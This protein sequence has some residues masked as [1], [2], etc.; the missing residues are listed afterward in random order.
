MISLKLQQPLVFR[1]IFLER[2]WGGRNLKKI[3][4]KPVPPGV[5]IGEAWEIV[6]RPEAQSVI[7][8]GPAKGRSLHELW[9]QHRTE[10]FGAIADA[11]RFPL[12]CKI[13]DAEE[14]LSLQVHPPAEVA[15]E[16]GGEAKTEFW[17]IAHAQP[18]AE[19]FVGLKKNSSRRSIEG[20]LPN[21][22]VEDHLHRIRVRDGD[23][24]FLPSGRMHAIGGGNVL[25]EVQQNS[26]TTYRVFDWNREDTKGASRKLHLAESMRSIDFED[27]EPEL[28]KPAGESLVR[29]AFFEIE[30]WT[31]SG[32]RTSVPMGKFAIFVCLSGKVACA[33]MSFA[34]GEFFLVPASMEN[35]TLQ[36]LAENTAVLR[37]TI[38]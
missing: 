18:D 2:I 9:S 31:L 15:K 22:K 30:K 33:E 8:A 29:H 24:M 1:P 37:V 19:I 16:L 12:L 3:Y 4:G 14:R 10:V 11:D 25:V 7:S 28:I 17:Y 26:D 5:R 38:P 35:R 23:A 27:Y 20:A 32:A 13:L 6:D 34:P 21:G 36:P